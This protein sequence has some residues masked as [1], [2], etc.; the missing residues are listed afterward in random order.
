MLSIFDDKKNN[1]QTLQIL[2]DDDKKAYG[3]SFMRHGFPQIVHANKEVILSTGTY[4]S[5]LLLMKSGIGPESI[6]NAAEV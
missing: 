4:S 5:P 3:V 6:L 1:S 2:L